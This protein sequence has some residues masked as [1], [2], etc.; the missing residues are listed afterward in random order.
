MSRTAPDGRRAGLS[1]PKVGIRWRWN[2]KVNEALQS[3]SG[4][5]RSLPRAAD[6]PVQA[7][8]EVAPALTLWPDDQR[9]ARWLRSA[10]ECC[11]AALRAEL[12]T[13]G[14][15]YQQGRLGA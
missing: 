4:R 11:I 15:Q 9:P 14:A 6:L 8:T 1:H 5:G 7:S 12:G 13:L 2:G 3:P 10:P